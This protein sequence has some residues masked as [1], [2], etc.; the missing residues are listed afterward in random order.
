MVRWRLAQVVIAAVAVGGA[1]V[2]AW[3]Q[4]PVAD[5]PFVV[6]GVTELM[7]GE[8]GGANSDLLT[9]DG[10]ISSLKD[11]SF[12]FWW[13]EDPVRVAVRDPREPVVL[14][15]GQ[16]HGG[17]LRVDEGK[18]VLSV[19]STEGA[20]DDGVRWPRDGASAFEL[21]WTGEAYHAFADGERLQPDLPGPPPEGAG[22]LN[23]FPGASV[24]GFGCKGADSDW[25]EVDGE[26][27]TAGIERVWWAL[28]STV[29]A[30]A[31]L[32]A[33]SAR[34]ARRPGA[35]TR[36]ATLLAALAL[37]VTALGLVATLQ[38][39]NS[40]RLGSV[41]VTCAD[42]AVDH[43]GPLRL[44]PGTPLDFGKRRD[45]DF[46]LSTRVALGERSV[47]DLMLRLAPG[48]ADRQVL[49]TL[50]TDPDLP[51]GVARNLSTS[52]QGRQAPEP[53]AVLVPRQLYTLEV[54]ARDELV[55]ARLDGQPFGSVRDYDLR[56]GHILWHVLTG[57]AALW[58]LS[59][60]PTGQPRALNDTLGRW[61]LGAV[62][63]LLVAAWACA[64]W[65]GWGAAGL[66]WLW[67]LAVV[68]LPPAPETLRIPGWIL[69]G[70]LLLLTPRRGRRAI[71]W[72]AGAVMVGLA[73]WVAGE[74][75]LV[76]T[77]SDLNLL[78]AAHVA[79]DPIPERYVWAR[80][81]L[82]RRFNSFVRS[83]TFRGERVEWDKPVGVTRIIALGGSATL[84]HGVTA[85]QAWPKQL[86]DLMRSQGRPEV[87]VINAGVSAATAELLR[88]HLL[89]VLLDLQPDVVVVNL[90]F[91]DHL[92]GGMV[93]EREH[94]AAMTSTGIGW[95]GG[96]V[97]RLR[98]PFAKRG[99]LEYERARSGGKAV[100]AED[101]QRYELQPARRFGDSLRDMVSVCHAA[102]AKV[103]FVSE[104]IRPGAR[105][106]VLD[107]YHEAMSALGTELGVPVVSVQADLDA[108]GPDTFMDIVH[109]TVQGQ[110]LLARRIALALEREVLQPR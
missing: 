51:G 24:A 67:P 108:L 97:G 18:L 55:E 43:P 88:Y 93:N 71:T 66:L 103:L 54:L 4:E 53:L 39:N 22:G 98:A 104:P 105:L 29:F 50:S 81:P 27:D 90:G 41:A 89:G 15:L 5:R 85:E 40:D 12:R 3:P 26:R 8:S 82:G 6:P 36:Q 70:L 84:G 38:E 56:E 25:S 10:R 96:L 60:E 91:N 62:V 19:S 42:T 78:D 87:Q 64:R 109:P 83:Q 1:V 30:L 77:P 76:V 2:L 21:V 14:R 63:G 107:A 28:L 73:V 46:R 33:G 58:D 11:V 79:G 68:S 102:G 52:L 80:H 48:G 16:A 100:S 74:R 9:G 59:V 69:A 72:F 7:F 61:L 17:R 95:W 65:S 20:D 45:G 37:T 106:P 101:E 44:L 13:V 92:R 34:L 49:I 57:E 35:S 110:E 94:F 32:R 47:L 31:C 23:F 99:W 86:E 75:F